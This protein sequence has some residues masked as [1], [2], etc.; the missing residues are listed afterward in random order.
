M[1]VHGVDVGDGP[2]ADVV[3]QWRGDRAQRGEQ[4]LGSAGRPTWV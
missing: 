2:L 1:A 3:V 4:R